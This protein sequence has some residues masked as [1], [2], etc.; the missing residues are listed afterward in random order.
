VGG[1]AGFEVEDVSPD[2]EVAAGVAPV[3][4]EAPV[5]DPSGATE[6]AVEPAFDMGLAAVERTAALPEHPNNTTAQRLMPKIRFIADKYAYLR[7]RTPARTVRSYSKHRQLL[8]FA[9]TCLMR[10]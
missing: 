6:A 7:V 1:V 9:I 2:G 10:V 3:F 5:P 8:M 4:E